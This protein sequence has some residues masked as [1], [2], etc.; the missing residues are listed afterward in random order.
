MQGRCRQP[1]LWLDSNGH[2]KYC[3]S[4][5]R[6]GARDHFHAGL[7]YLRQEL[8]TNVMLVPYEQEPQRH[9][10]FIFTQPSITGTESSSHNNFHSSP[11]VLLLQNQ[12]KTKSDFRSEESCMILNPCGQWEQS[13]MM[14]P[15]LLKF[16]F[17][18]R[19]EKKNRTFGAYMVSPGTALFVCLF[20]FDVTSGTWSKPRAA[21]M[22][23]RD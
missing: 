9:F 16:Y 14:H 12:C 15:G 23:W 17:L 20:K 6:P 22:L 21:W 10:H 11:D 4:P 8:F 1:L 5:A 18:K 3:T 19:R 7:R 13:L 2:G